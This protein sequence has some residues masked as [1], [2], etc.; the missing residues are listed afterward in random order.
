MDSVDERFI[1]ITLILVAI[2]VFTFV[3]GYFN[4]KYKKNNKNDIHK[5]LDKSQSVIFVLITFF[6]IILVPYSLQKPWTIIGI[7]TMIAVSA[8]I[9]GYLC[10]FI[11]P[12]RELKIFING[13]NS[14]QEL[15]FKFLF[16]LFLYYNFSYV[17]GTGLT[18]LFNG[19][20]NPQIV[21]LTPEFV[22]YTIPTIS[23]ITLIIFRITKI[24][25]S[26]TTEYLGEVTQDI[27]IFSFLMYWL[28]AATS[29]LG[30][31]IQAQILISFPQENTLTYIV[32]ILFGIAFEGLVIWIKKDLEKNTNYVSFEEMIFLIFEMFRKRRVIQR[33]MDDFYMEH[34]I[35]KRNFNLSGL[36][37]KI[38]ARFNIKYKGHNYKMS[39]LLS[40]VFLVLLILFA[41]IIYIV[42]I[43]NEYLVVA[44]AYLIDLNIIPQNELPQNAS[45]IYSEYMTSI[46]PNKLYAIPIV[47]IHIINFSFSSPLSNRFLSLNS[48]NFFVSKTGEYL[49]IFL[50]KIF[51]ETTISFSSTGNISYNHKND[52][53]FNYMGFFRDAEIFYCL[54]KFGYNQTVA[55][56][57][58]SIMSIDYSIQQKLIFSSRGD[59][60]YSLVTINLLLPYSDETILC[61]T[62]EKYINETYFLIEQT[63]II[64]KITINP[65]NPN[66]PF[67]ILD[68]PE[69]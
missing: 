15:I 69:N 58:S 44:P 48:S 6:I 38:D 65:T 49:I 64:T 1:Y 34:I 46:S 62:N 68:I 5:S 39:Q 57:I 26:K 63:K 47:T 11:W 25:P 36:L 30:I 7:V 40:W 61:S 37:K 55:L 54:T 24:Q 27:V 10:F 32:L 3:F 51:V 18:F 56:S 41:L 60:N 8:L 53:T 66:I 35:I 20:I 31:R 17:I 21:M 42:E 43:P 16:I 2:F 50:K 45:I 13:K 59:D 19:L 9:V 14:R 12:F 67:K 33:K 23:V 22:K 52:P 4:K 28:S 29:L